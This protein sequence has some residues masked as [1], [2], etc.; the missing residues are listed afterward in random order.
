MAIRTTSTIMNI[1]IKNSLI[2]PIKM[3]T[4]IKRGAPIPIKKVN[5]AKVKEILRLGM[6]LQKGRKQ[7]WSRFLWMMAFFQVISQMNR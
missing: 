3:S 2:I 4:I 7:A 1:I 6:C 5:F